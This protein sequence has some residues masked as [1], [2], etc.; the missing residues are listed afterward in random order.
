MVVLPEGGVIQR[1]GLTGGKGLLVWV[2]VW[3]LFC[4]LFPLSFP[5]K[6]PLPAS[7]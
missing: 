6:H 5:M 3:L 4:L 2:F 1:E 7:S